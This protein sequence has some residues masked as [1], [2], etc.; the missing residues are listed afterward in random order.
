MQPIFI[1]AFFSPLFATLPACWSTQKDCTATDASGPDENT[2]SEIGTGADSDVDADVDVDADADADTDSDSDSDSDSDTDTSTS[3]DTET[4]TGLPC[5]R[6][7]D[8]ASL[9]SNPTGMYWHDAFTNINDGLE[10]AYAE[11]L[12]YP[13][14]PRCE[15]WVAEGTYYIYTDDEEDTVL[16]RPRIH[17]YGGFT[18]TEDQLS[19]R[20]WIG[21]RTVLDGRAY[22]GAE[23]RVYHVVTGS[24]TATIDGFEIKNGHADGYY[25]DA[26][27]TTCSGLF[28]E[29]CKGGGML[30]LF[31]S[32]IVKNCTFTDNVAEY[33]GGMYNE[34]ASPKISDCGF[35][36]N[37]AS[38]G[39][40][41]SNASAS[42]T[43][44]NCTFTDNGLTSTDP[45]GVCIGGG[46]YSQ[47]GAPIVGGCT[48]SDN[49]ATGGGGIYSMGSAITI[50]DCSFMNNTATMRGGGL[51]TGYGTNTVVKCDF[52][53]NS[54]AM[55]GGL[56]NIGAATTTIAGCSFDANT[57]TTAGG[58][59]NDFTMSSGI[60]LIENSIFTNNEAPSGSA[61]D[62]TESRSITVNSTFTLNVSDEASGGTISSLRCTPQIINSILWGNSPAAL[63]TID[64][65]HS[66]IEGGLEGEGNIDADPL[67]VDAAG[68]DFKLMPGSP[69][70][71]AAN[72][73]WAPLADKEGLSRVDDPS[74]ANTGTGEINYTDIGALE[75]T[76]G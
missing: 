28:A 59:I 20:D 47:G 52:Q 71:D 75:Y 33:G 68:G 73:E 53:G 51:V 76:P 10:S 13:A 41:I 24:D 69:C 14:T 63:G 21:N 57:A 46:I 55:G 61:I 38:Y 30:N 37:T 56:S 65:T 23:D 39:S 32:P 35:A 19:H 40:G 31:G 1:C 43:I 9:A 5:R 62:N 48:F 54:A 7:V 44:S 25:N 22:D 45:F 2:D 4:G 3:T 70:I 29:H 64:A 12:K 11:T 49:S 26:R 15:V 58:A 16:L 27:V 42:P 66:V 60:T 50:V 17:L 6:Y 72:G 18:G 34:A 8:R 67:L 36:G 74:V